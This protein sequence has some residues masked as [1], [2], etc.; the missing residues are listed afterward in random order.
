M[1]DSHGD[2]SQREITLGLLNAVHEN[3]RVTQRS[4]AK[5]LGIALGLTNAYLKRCIKKGLIKVKA[6]PANRYAYYLTPQGFAE[7]SRLTS[8]YLTQ[9]FLFFRN[10]R[11][12][13]T[14]LLGLCADRGWRRVALAG[15]GDLAEIAALCA[16][17][18][19]IELVATDP[20]GDA[21]GGPRSLANVPVVAWGHLPGI[22]AALVTDIANPQKTFEAMLSLLPRE[23]VLAPRFLNISTPARERDGKEAYHA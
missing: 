18:H 22:D 16:L 7:K 10:A 11:V 13:C 20:G 6:V 2:G 17:E 19:D 14:E 15:I 12:E 1:T 8:E 5:D 4:V 3:A 9:S 21:G 23:R